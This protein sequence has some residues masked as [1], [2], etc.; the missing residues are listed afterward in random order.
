VSWALVW[1]RD[2]SLAACAGFIL[3]HDL[4]DRFVFGATWAVVAAW[5]LERY[6]DAKRPSP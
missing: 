6:L 4:I 5:W 3:R 2:I 1:I